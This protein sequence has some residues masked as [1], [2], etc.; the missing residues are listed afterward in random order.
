MGLSIAGG[1]YN[2]NL[3]LSLTYRTALFSDEKAQMFL[4]LY[5]EEIKNYQVGV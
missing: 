5:V 4:N 1:I 2:R 3:N